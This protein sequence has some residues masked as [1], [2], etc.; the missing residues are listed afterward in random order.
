MGMWE[1]HGVCH[2][3]ADRNE[4]ARPA[5]E[6]WEESCAVVSQSKTARG[7]VDQKSR[8]PPF[9]VRNHARNVNM[10]LPIAFTYAHERTGLSQSLNFN[11]AKSRAKGQSPSHPTG[12]TSA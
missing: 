7:P 1:I 10:A 6:G 5:A 4:Q 11:C 8:M 12:I 9:L 2:F 3:S